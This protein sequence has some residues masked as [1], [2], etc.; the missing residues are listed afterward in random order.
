MSAAAK[1]KQLF[2]RT[3]QTTQEYVVW[4]MKIGQLL[5][6]RM[7]QSLVE[8]VDLTF[9]Q[10]RIL[11]IVH[12]GKEVHPEGITLRRLATI[13]MVSLPNVNGLVERLQGDGYLTKKRSAKDKR[14]HYLE[15]TPKGKKLL[16]MLKKKWPPKEL[17]GIDQ[18]FKQL[19]K[20]QRDLFTKTLMEMASY[21]HERPQLRS[22]G[23]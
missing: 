4:M 9:N 16:I 6:Q 20:P 7:N 1:S 22:K 2:H 3:P 8:R 5:T 12:H 21:L 23:K 10:V 18:F 14:S 13:L 11:F 17:A 15:L 19:S